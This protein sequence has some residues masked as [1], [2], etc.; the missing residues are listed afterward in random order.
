MTKLINTT[1]FRSL[2]VA[3]CMLA[4]RT[5]AFIPNPS[6]TDEHARS[7]TSPPPSMKVTGSESIT[8][9]LSDMV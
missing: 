3:S 4:G 7:S 1:A 9:L 8:I 6:T 2:L 5:P